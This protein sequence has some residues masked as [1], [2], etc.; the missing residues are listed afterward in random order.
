[1]KK[2]V[3]LFLKGMLM[4]ICDIIPGI[5]GGTIAFI[6]GIYER[7]ITSVKS[8]SPELFR[9]FF[10]YISTRKKENLTKLKTD[11]KKLDLGFL[12]IIVAGIAT[13]VLAG[14]RVISFLLENYFSYTM[15]FFIGLIIVSSKIIFDHIEKHHT[16]NV[17]FG[18]M[19]LLLG[20]SLS[21][22]IPVEI[23]PTISYVFLGGF[24]AISAMFLPGISGAFIL[25][26]MGLYSFMLNV[27]RD[28]KIGYMMVFFFGAG[29]GAFTISR[30]VSFLFSKDKC[31]TLYFLLGLVLGALSIPVKRVYSA[32]AEWS[33]TT[34]GFTLFFIALGALSVIMASSL[35]ANNK[36]KKIS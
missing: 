16:K 20:I 12:T 36:N 7:L 21:V 29:L 17:L 35:A 13:A 5:S 1:M 2:A 32:S 30:I 25:L 8:F 6:T 24:L 34:V 14:V 31:K 10:R 19:G 26:I 23:A 22:L 33:I 9:D 28:I 27:L 15:S 18:L 3:V 11:I 4:G